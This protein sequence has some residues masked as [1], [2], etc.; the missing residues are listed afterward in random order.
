MAEIQPKNHQNVQKQH[1]WQKAAGGNG[2][3]KDHC[4]W[5]YFFSRIVSECEQLSVQMCPDVFAWD[6]NEDLNPLWLIA[7]F[8]IKK[9]IPRCPVA[10]SVGCISQYVTLLWKPGIRDKLKMHWKNELKMHY[11]IFQPVGNVFQ[12]AVIIFKCVGFVS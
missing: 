4:D 9:K 12:S 10:I 3:K 2:L 1:F 7:H 5:K 6:L 8:Q 11:N